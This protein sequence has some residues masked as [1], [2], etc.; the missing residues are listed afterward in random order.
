MTGN[1][2][3]IGTES[4]SN[5]FV[6]YYEKQSASPATIAHF[7]RLKAMLLRVL[8]PTRPPQQTR[9]LDIGCGAGSFC[10]VWAE[11]GFD[12]SGADINPELIE[13]ARN[14]MKEAGLAIEFHTGSAS[15]LPW[16]D[17]SFSIVAMPELLE[18]VDDWQSCLAEAIRVLAPGGVLYLSTTNVLCPK[19]QEFD[20][21]LYSWY[22]EA[23]KRHCV[24][25]AT[26]TQ[27][28]WV[29]Y[30]RFPA[31]NWFSPRKLSSYLSRRG[32]TVFDRFGIWATYSQNRRQRAIGRMISAVPA[33]DLM[34]HIATP[35]T[36]L[37][38]LK[39]SA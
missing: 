4:P 33:L 15:V 8:S 23:I 18:H 5:P 7:Q 10:Q 3:G 21:P 20:L 9:V 36:V 27:R 1:T 6:A 11:S 25:L 31:V 37:V 35:S 13:I 29:Q 24:K 38:A 39:I 22:P 26:S 14:R 34:G 12:V 32:M 28:Q 19:Q 2:S 30:A 17:A 16:P